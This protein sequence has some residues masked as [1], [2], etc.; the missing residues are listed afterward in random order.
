MR[1][2]YRQDLAHLGNELERMSD[3]VIRAIERA[4]QALREGDLSLAEQ[5]I[6]AD[7]RLDE[8]ARTIDEMCLNLLTLQGPVAS[9]LRLILAAL[10][11]SQIMERQG[12]LARHI[13]MIARSTYPEHSISEDAADMVNSMGAAA[14]DMAHLQR[15]LLVELDTRLGSDFQTKDDV[16]DDLQ[17][18]VRRFVLDDYHAL[19]RR[20]VIDLTLAARFLERFGDHSVSMGRRILF[21][22]EGA[23]TAE[24]LGTGLDSRL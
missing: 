13:A 15:K 10:R 18:E 14:V 2:L 17:T 21:I 23:K 16:L 3:G 20:Q 11:L 4:T 19:T 22:I 24:E 8:A 12:D 9:D 1:E 6:D 5:T 7:E